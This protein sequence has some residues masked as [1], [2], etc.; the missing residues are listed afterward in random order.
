MSKFD[1]NL[2]KLLF[3]GTGSAFVA[4]WFAF[5]AACYGGFA[6]LYRNWDRC[7]ESISVAFA[8]SQCA[9]PSWSVSALVVSLCVGVAL[10]LL[11]LLRSRSGSDV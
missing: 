8:T 9:Y 1:D 6:G 2:S 11:L 7:T 4:A 3:Y 10:Y 5:L